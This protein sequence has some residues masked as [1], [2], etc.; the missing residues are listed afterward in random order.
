MQKIIWSL[1]YLAVVNV[2]AWGIY[3]IDKEKAKRGAWRIPEAWLIGWALAGGSLGAWLGMKTF[4]HKTRKPKFR[5]GVPA[6]L[7]VQVIV[8][9]Y[10]WCGFLGRSIL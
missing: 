2:A 6:I 4:H 7:L 9:V 3:G 1:C 8:A 5:Y 10:F